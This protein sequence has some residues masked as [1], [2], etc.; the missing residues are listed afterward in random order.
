MTQSSGRWRV[1]KHSAAENDL[2]AGVA[3]A[4]A[5][6]AGG[7]GPTAGGYS[8]KK[9]RDCSEVISKGL[10]QRILAQESLSSRRTM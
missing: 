5:P 10:R 7:V 4:V 9:A 3:K 8:L 1:L 6:A 2:D